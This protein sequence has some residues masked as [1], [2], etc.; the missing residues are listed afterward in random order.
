MTAGWHHGTVVAAHTFQC[1]SVERCTDSTNLSCFISTIKQWQKDCQRD[2]MHQSKSF[3]LEEVGSSVC[4]CY[5]FLGIICFYKAVFF[6]LHIHFECSHLLLRA[7]VLSCLCAEA[8]K[9]IWSQNGKSQ[10]ENHRFVLVNHHCQSLFVCVECNSGEGRF[11]GTS[12]VSLHVCHHHP[13]WVW[14]DRCLWKA[15]GSTR[16]TPPTTTTTPTPMALVDPFPF[17]ID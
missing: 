4:L 17:S 1:Y 14:L 5:F 10:E 12:A 8:A 2:N 11:L 3:C 13:L 15:C 9:L 7:G 6:P 16:N